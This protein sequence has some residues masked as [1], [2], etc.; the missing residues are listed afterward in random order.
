[1]HRLFSV[2]AIT[3]S[4]SLSFDLLFSVTGDNAVQAEVFKQVNPDGSVTFTDKPKSKDETPV[5][6]QPMSTFKAP[7][8][9]PISSSAKAQPAAVEYTSVSITSPGN[10]DTIRDNTGNLTVTASVTPGLQSGHKMVLLDNGK[11]LGESASGSFELSNIDRG[12]HTLYVQI[13]DSSG[14]ALITSEPVT[15]YLH[16]RSIRH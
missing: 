10:E 1:M 11:S 5:P 16:R 7:K 13:Q 9:P 3:L 14:E 12:A 15:V 4:L 6:L 8:A 2:L